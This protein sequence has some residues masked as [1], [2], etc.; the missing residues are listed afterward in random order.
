M[1]F[2]G[3]DRY[4]NSGDAQQGFWFF[5]NP[6]KLGTNS[7]GGG[8]GFTGVHKNGD[9]LVISDFS[10]GG[11][12]STITVY[13]WDSTCAKAASK[14][15]PGDCGDVNLRLLS[16][17][18]NAK[19]AASLQGNDNSCGIVNAANGTVAPWPYTDKSGNSTYLQGELYEGGI[20]LSTLGLSTECF[21][22]IA[23]ETRSSTSTTAVLKDFVLGGFGECGAGLVTT[24]SGDTVLS[25]VTGTATVS[26]S[27]KISVHGSNPPAPTG[28][29]AFYL[30]GP[31]ATALTSCDSTGT[32]KGSVN[33]NT[34]TH[35][36]NDY[37]VG[38]GDV[39]VNASGYYCWFA[40][41][42]G[43]NNYKPESPA[44]AF[45]DGSATECFSV[46][47]PT[48]VT[49]T[50]H[51]TDANGVDISAE[52]QQRHDDHDQRRRPRRRLRDRFAVVGDGQ[53][54]V[55][56]LQRRNRPGRL[57]RRHDRRRRHVRRQWRGVERL[58]HGSVVTPTSGV[59]R[60]KAFYTATAGSLFNSSMSDCSEILTVRQPTSV[61]TTLH[62]TD[63]DG[64]DVRRTPTTA[65]R[66]R[67]TP[68]ATSSTTR[69]FRRRRR[70]AASCSATTAAQP[71]WP[72]APPTRPPPSGTSAGS[73]AVSSGSAHGSVV[74]PTSGVY[75]FKAF[76]TATAGSLFNSSISDCSEILTVRQPT[77]VTTTL[78]ETD[79]NGVDVTPNA[80]NGTTI[81]INAGG[82]VVDYATVSPSSATGSVVFRYYSG[83]TALADCTADA[84]AAGGTSAGSGA[85]SSG[86]AHGSV[87]T[88]TSGVYR[89]KAFYTATAGSLFNGSISDCSRS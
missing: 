82:H 62:E 52:R 80:N 12:T 42:P 55:P 58:R 40:T 89:F 78:H 23:S 76:Y 21:S 59:Y 47:Q 10:N 20:N 71:P 11:T 61:T 30:C 34:A 43:D 33:L 85:V 2:F 15:N 35:T 28:L 27:A 72:T 69:P 64:V 36:G 7:V 54:R 14:P 84:T 25:G 3:S 81:T 5:Q 86:S 39:T 1:I 31:S 19:C 48:S 77:S 53:R 51:E 70:R 83:A 17:S 38:S 13:K 46:R 66:S 50:L 65:R 60:F 26:D 29:V 18:D 73:G 44:T 87:V 22:S 79:A 4:D 57:H 75:R 67:S 6:V 24:P 32:S 41:W 9:V 74:T 88:P 68:A 37:T 56:L 45:S 63:A 8:T 49:T 16:T